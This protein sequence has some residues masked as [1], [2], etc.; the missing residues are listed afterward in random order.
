MPRPAA[1]LLV[2]TLAVALAGCF[3]GD[4]EAELTPAST[5]TLADPADP[6]GPTD[7]EAV[8]GVEPS[9]PPPQGEPA[10]GGVEGDSASI[11]LRP[12]TPEEL[13]RLV[14]ENSGKVVLVD[15]WA[16]WCI[17]C[18]QQYPHSVELSEKYADD[19]VVYS[20]SMNDTD[21]ETLASV[22]EQLSDWPAGNVRPLISA[23]GGEQE[24]FT[25]FEITDGA[26][27]HYK[28]YG[29]DGKLVAALGGIDETPDP[30]KVDAAVEQALGK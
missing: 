10:S 4:P 1:P 18:L 22:K 6:E 29:R 13:N 25:A 14:A 2:T 19:L 27:P 15:F 16:T 20:V 11:E 8:P 26:L 24:A 17:P 5:S 21:E 9:A 28:I 12:V 3:E 23:Q 7:P 30:E